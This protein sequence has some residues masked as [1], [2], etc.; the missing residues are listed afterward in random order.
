M[1]GSEA[2]SFTTFSDPSSFAAVA[3]QTLNDSRQTLPT[4]IHLYILR[5]LDKETL[6]QAELDGCIDGPDCPNMVRLILDWRAAFREITHGHH[7]A[8]VDFDMTTSHDIYLRHNGRVVQMLS[9][10]L[11]LKETPPRRISFSVRGCTEEHRKMIEGCLPAGTIGTAAGLP[12]PA[13]VVT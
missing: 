7:V 6:T 12:G 11:Y 5:S 3:R 13:T 1:N 8:H 4:H 2:P 10:A 9:T